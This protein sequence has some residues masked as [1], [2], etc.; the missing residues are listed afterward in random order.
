M[1]KQDDILRDKL[2]RDRQLHNWLLSIGVPE[3]MQ[4]IAGDASNRRFFRVKWGN[5]TAI[6]VDAPPPLENIQAFIDR[7][8][9][10]AKGQLLR[11][12]ACYQAHTEKGF[13]LTEDFGNI[14]LLEKL[15][16]DEKLL[17]HCID[18]LIELQ[19]FAADTATPLYTPALLQEE[20]QLF[21]MWLID[22]HLGMNIPENLDFSALQN[23]ILQEISTQNTCLVHRDFHSRNLMY[24][25][26]FFGVI[27]FQDACIGSHFYDLASLLRDAYAQVSAIEPYL[28]YYHE[29]STLTH[30]NLSTS[31]EQFNWINIQRQL[32]VAGIFARLH[33]RDGKANYLPYLPRVLT[34]LSDSLHMVGEHTWQHWITQIKHALIAQEN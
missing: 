30:N 9:L 12:P 25:Q 20:M 10:F 32:K 15:Q 17:Y 11:S 4:P 5:S 14:M 6:A 7:S 2:L 23:R 34:Y 24:C 26:N 28:Q 3:H 19:S 16:Q 8:T 29:H 27:D 21:N 31:I 18:A 1:N 33:W 13:A 22:I